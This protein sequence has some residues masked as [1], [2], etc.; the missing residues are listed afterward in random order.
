MSFKKSEIEI[1][2]IGQLPIFKDYKIR[3]DRYI[4]FGW[5]TLKCAI[6]FKDEYI[7]LN[8]ETKLKLKLREWTKKNWL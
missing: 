8:G 5:T 7:K 1:E 2:V 6:P 4:G 3:T